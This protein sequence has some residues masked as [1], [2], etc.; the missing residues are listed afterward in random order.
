MPRTAG[1]DLERPVWQRPLQCL[2]FCP[3][4]SEPDLALLVLQAF[5][6]QNAKLKRETISA[7]VDPCLLPAPS[8]FWPKTN[9]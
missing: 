5:G 8:P 9:L 1:D 2:R 3:G 6:L 4:R 7:I